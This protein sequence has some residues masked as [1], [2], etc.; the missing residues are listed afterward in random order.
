M[1][2]RGK[3]AKAA[4]GPGEHCSCAL[5]HCLCR[6][7]RPQRKRRGGGFLFARRG[8]GG[9]CSCAR[10]DTACLPLRPQAVAV[11]Q[12]C[13]P[14]LFSSSLAVLQPLSL[15]VAT[16]RDGI[17]G[18][19]DSG[20]AQRPLGTQVVV[21]DCPAIVYVANIDYHQWKWPQSPRGGVADPVVVVVFVVAQE[22]WRSFAS[23]DYFD[24][25]GVFAG[26]V[27]GGHC[28]RW[29]SMFAT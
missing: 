2:R 26:V 11:L 28:R 6:G 1:D 22:H 15:L 3:G 18:R 20:C 9:G 27:I 29:Q 24:R 5:Q 8:R 13:N 10:E 17:A 25:R 23:Q 14:F 19:P 21:F 4:L 12:C 16:R 7:E